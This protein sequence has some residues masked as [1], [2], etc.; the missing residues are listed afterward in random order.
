MNMNIVRK[1]PARLAITEFLSKVDAPVDIEQIIDYLHS[2][3]LKTNKVTVYRIIEYFY[4]KEIVSR[5]DLQE[6]KFRYEIKRNDHHHLICDN[7]GSIDAV[8]DTVIPEMEKE[9]Q[10]KQHFLV[11]RHSLE[12]FGICRNCQH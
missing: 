1:T 9:I 2:K 8:S 12:F 4:K 6:G 7:C 11:K 3:N 10:Q 5:L